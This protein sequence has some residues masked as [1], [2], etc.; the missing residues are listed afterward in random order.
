[1]TTSPANQQ[2]LRAAVIGYMEAWAG[3][4][5]ALAA[6][7]HWELV[8]IAD[9]QAEQQQQASQAHPTVDILDDGLLAIDDPSIDLIAIT[10]LADAR[11]YLMRKAL[12][13]GKHIW[14]EKPIAATIEE[15]ESLLADITASDQLVAVNMFNR[16]AWYHEQLQAFIASGQIGEI[17]CIRVQH[18]TPGMRF[19][20]KDTS[21]KAPVS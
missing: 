17:A 21:Q 6:D 3:T 14:A 18:Q 1:M 13:A 19:L 8:A 20:A 12:A 16:N 4:A 2:L 11:P 5:T 9:R 15:E 10:T 7:P